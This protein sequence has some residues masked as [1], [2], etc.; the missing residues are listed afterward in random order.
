[1]DIFKIPNSN[2]ESRFAGA[3]AEG[4]ESSMDIFNVH[5]FLKM[6]PVPQFWN[7]V[8]IR[9]S[10][11][12]SSCCMVGMAVPLGACCLVN[13]VWDTQFSS[14][15]TRARKR[16]LSCSTNNSCRASFASKRRVASFHYE[17]AL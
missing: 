17:D 16:K 11:R 3:A 15:A 4:R 7:M 9:V 5:I 12:T 10:W 1:M 8:A 14:D 2:R 6:I 13:P